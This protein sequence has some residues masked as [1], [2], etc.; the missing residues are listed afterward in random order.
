MAASGGDTL[1]R[2]AA[3]Q[4]AALRVKRR[5]PENEAGRKLAEGIDALLGNM[6]TCVKLNG[7]GV[8]RVEEAARLVA[9]A[10]AVNTTATAV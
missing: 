10:L 2:G 4:E 8:G 5:I 6:V 9:S 1:W 7:F 3:L